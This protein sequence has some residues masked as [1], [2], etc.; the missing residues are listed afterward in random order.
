VR[1]PLLLDRDLRGERRDLRVVH[2]PTIAPR[3]RRHRSAVEHHLLLQLGKLLLLLRQLPACVPRLLNKVEGVRAR[4][5]DLG[6]QQ[7]DLR[8]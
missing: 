7:T 6:A 5:P 3:P 2:Q 1:E 8:L 4:L